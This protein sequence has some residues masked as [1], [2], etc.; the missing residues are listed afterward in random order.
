MPSMHFSPF[1]SFPSTWVDSVEVVG[2]GL[3]SSLPSLLLC[4]LL[5][6][7]GCPYT[8]SGINR[9]PGWQEGCHVFDLTWFCS[10][11]FSTSGEHPLLLFLS[12]TS[13]AMVGCLQAV[14]SQA[15]VLGREWMA[16]SFSG[17]VQLFPGQNWSQVEG[18][19]TLLPPGLFCFL[20]LALSL[21]LPS[22]E[23]WR[24]GH[25]L[26]SVGKLAM[27]ETEP[28]SANQA[29]CPAQIWATFCHC[30]S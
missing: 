3:V 8:H 17:R 16:A 26:N 29:S 10:H 21:T 6:L 12:L 27:A 22:R 4:F 14:G 19:R 7:S 28:G 24:T 20:L 2:G 25:F 9:A 15:H 11:M 30:R 1:C 5:P 18:S 23:V 13:F